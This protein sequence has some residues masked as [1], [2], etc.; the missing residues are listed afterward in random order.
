[1]LSKQGF[2]L[3]ANG[4]DKTVQLSEESNQYPFAG[5]KEILNTIFNEVM[6]QGIGAVLDIGFG[7]GVL[8]TK[9]YEHGHQISG[10]DFSSK[11]LEIAKTKMPLAHL[12]EWDLNNGLP[13]AHFDTNYDAIISTYA[14]HHLTD[15][16]KVDYILELLPQ[17]TQSGKIY[18]GDIAFETQEQLEK[19]RH[20]SVDYWDD[21]EYYFVHEQFSRLLDGKCKVEFHPISHCG[22]IFVISKL[23]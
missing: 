5:Y 8:T 17:L 12:Y 4:Y 10:F 23:S 19:C 21:D 14:L 11:M 13:V 1:M 6:Q 9:L 15:E 16:R 22:G 20:E 3:W 18:I 7:T 2:D